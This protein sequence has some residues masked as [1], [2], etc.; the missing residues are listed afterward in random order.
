MSLEDLTLP[1][2]PAAYLGI[3]YIEDSTLVSLL[4]SVVSTACSILV[5]LLHTLFYVLRL[6]CYIFD[7]TSAVLIF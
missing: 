7:F 6:Y 5:Y 4:Y 3:E 2:A 1:N